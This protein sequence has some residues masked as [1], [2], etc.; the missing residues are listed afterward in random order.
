[1][2]RIPIV[3]EDDPATPPETREFLKR[4]KGGH[5]EVFNGVRL[6][7]NHP[8]QANALLDFVRSVRHHNSLTPTLTELAYT[9]AS[10]A[11]RC[12]Y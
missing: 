1:M 9:T 4:V 5:G 7:A 11:N 2:A 12:H 6:L 10:V 3:R 8:Q